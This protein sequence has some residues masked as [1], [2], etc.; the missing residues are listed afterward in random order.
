MRDCDPA[1]Y[2]PAGADEDVQ[3]RLWG[4]DRKALEDCQALNAAKGAAIRAYQGQGKTAE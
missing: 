2:I 1:T 4:Q 3:Y